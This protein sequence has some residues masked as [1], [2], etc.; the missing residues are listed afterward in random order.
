MFNQSID[1][2]TRWKASKKLEE[3]RYKHYTSIRKPE[4]LAGDEAQTSVAVDCVK[5][6]LMM[7]GFF[8]LGYS[9]FF[10]DNVDVLQYLHQPARFP[11]GETLS[12]WLM[13]CGLVLV[14][15]IGTEAE[16]LIHVSPL[17]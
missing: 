7:F 5:C 17:K 15:S 4:A 11:L 3:N 9:I 1:R 12:P 16:I 2:T 10:Y 14:E 13:R 6:S 8:P